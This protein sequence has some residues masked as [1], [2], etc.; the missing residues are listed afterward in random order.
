MPQVKVVPYAKYYRKKLTPKFRAWL[1]E[2]IVKHQSLISQAIVFVNT[3]QH[4]DAKAFGG[5]VTVNVGLDESSPDE[6]IYTIFVD[7]IGDEIRVSVEGSEDPTPECQ[8]SWDSLMFRVK[9]LVRGS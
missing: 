3:R 6:K 8:E 9:G 4:N 7:K 1:L 2:Q 5:N